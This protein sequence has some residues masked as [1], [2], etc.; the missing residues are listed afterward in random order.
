LGKFFFGIAYGGVS[1]M[2]SLPA[3]SWLSR[4]KWRAKPR[5]EVLELSHGFFT[6]G[7]N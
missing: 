2:W 3:P 1:G 7:Y 5:G 6:I 4:R